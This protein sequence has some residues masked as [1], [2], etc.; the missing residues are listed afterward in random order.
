[1]WKNFQDESRKAYGAETANVS[2]ELLVAGCLQRIATA[3]ESMAQNYDTLI[4]DRAR[5][6]RLWKLAEARSEHACRRI[7][8]LK[9]AITRLKRKTC[10]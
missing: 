3:A 5:Y 9:G 2:A 4:S 6:E 8:A 1:M 10:R 7:A